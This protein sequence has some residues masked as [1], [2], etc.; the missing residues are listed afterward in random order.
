[1][2]RASHGGTWDLFTYPGIRS[3]SDMF[4]FGYDFHPWPTPKPIAPGADI[5][6]YLGAVIRD[7]GLQEHIRYNHKITHAALA[8]TTMTKATRWN[9]WVQRASQDRLSTHR[10]GILRRSSMLANMSL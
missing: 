6:E 4:T 10:S 2:G 8:I 9:L 3:D 7:S 5:L 1:M